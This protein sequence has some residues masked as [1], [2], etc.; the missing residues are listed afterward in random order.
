MES[1][2]K[3]Q[4]NKDISNQ[5]IENINYLYNF[6]SGDSQNAT[7]KQYKQARAVWQDFMMRILTENPV[8][9]DYYKQTKD[10]SVVNFIPKLVFKE[11]YDGVMG[12]YESK[13]NTIELNN[14]AFAIV[15]NKKFPITVGMCTLGHELEHYLQYKINIDELLDTK[16]KEKY[17]K[18][19][20]D[21]KK[22]THHNET[23]GMD[24]SLNKF[25][26]DVKNRINIIE[27]ESKLV[28]ISRKYAQSSKLAKFIYEQSLLPEKKL[29]KV[30]ETE[31]YVSWAHEEDARYKGILFADIVLN[32]Y[33]KDERIRNNPDVYM[34]LGS[35]RN[36]IDIESENSL[37]GMY[38]QRLS[39]YN[40]FQQFKDALTNPSKEFLLELERLHIGKVKSKD[41]KT[42][43]SE[44]VNMCFNQMFNGKQ[45]VEEQGLAFKLIIGFAG[46]NK[47]LEENKNNI[48]ASMY[49]ITKE[50]IASVVNKILQKVYLYK[51]D[52]AIVLSNYLRDIILNS[53]STFD[54]DFLELLY[55]R[56]LLQKEDFLNVISN[57]YKE[58][59]RVFAER[60][61][62]LIYNIEFLKPEEVNQVVENYCLYLQNNLDQNILP[63]LNKFTKKKETQKDLEKVRINIDSAIDSYKEYMHQNSVEEDENYLKLLKLCNS[64]K[65]QEDREDENILNM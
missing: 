53:P 52:N 21:L 19:I 22:D 1:I 46:M 12:T 30:F 48:S 39:Y 13:N 7:R 38:N 35:L 28:E 24:T 42:G 41:Q 44:L 62:N 32:T 26:E 4:K 6:F 49:K 47:T 29:S 27:D 55:R 54:A 16:T 34:W 14:Y 11:Y 15:A 57:N 65:L 56:N 2:I 31:K 59:W 8:G 18:I 10:G 25:S 61:V 43:Y 9:I 33:L 64:Y 37:K 5:Q 3:W 20:T 23:A 63:R 36:E 45:S 60:E 40:K 50:S 17:I 58:S 51:E